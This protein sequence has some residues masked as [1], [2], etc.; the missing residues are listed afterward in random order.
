MVRKMEIGIMS[1]DKFKQ[2]TL[3][4]AEGKRK[5]GKEEPKVWF[6]SIESLAQVL[7]SKNRELLKII[8]ERT[9]GSL[10]ELA[11]ATGRSPGN[12]SRTLKN[13]EQ[14]GIVELRKEKKA[15]KPLVCFDSFEAEFGY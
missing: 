11:D 8:K 1:R 4:I 3:D 12:L 5:P 2:Y 10:K 15:V 7:S 9:P 14:Y 13:M 6:D